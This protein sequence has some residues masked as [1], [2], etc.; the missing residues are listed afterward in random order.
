LN[1]EL[2]ARDLLARNAIDAQGDEEHSEESLSDWFS[3]LFR[4]P[5]KGLDQ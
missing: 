1:R 5:D 3:N 2:A 4:R